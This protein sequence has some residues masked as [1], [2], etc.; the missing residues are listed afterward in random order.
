MAE[1]RADE[2]LQRIV[3]GEPLQRLERKVAYNGAT[4]MPIR[5]EV[6]ARHGEQVITRNAYGAH[7]L[8]SPNAMF[9]DIDFAT[10]HAAKPAILAFVVL[11]AASLVTGWMLHSWGKTFGLLFVSLVAAAPLARLFARLVVAARGGYEHISRER[12]ASFIS[13]NPSWNVRLYRTPAGHRVLATHQPFVAGAEEV[14]G[15]F[16]AVS[17]DPVYV[18]MCTNQGCFRARL[19]AKPWRIGISSPMRPRPG[20]WPVR[21]ESVATRNAWIATYES[22]A[23]A[24]AACRYVESLG[25]GVVHESLKSVV[26][27]HDRESR[28]LSEALL[29]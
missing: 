14:Q 24:F 12:I 10:E 8:N 19:T 1:T 28:A 13:A 29:G 16:A 21:P 17:A 25:S 27:L 3:S 5:E 6:L 9:A 15:F 4:G 22:K 18:R 20:V 7:C 23:Q 11:A 2:A 26:D